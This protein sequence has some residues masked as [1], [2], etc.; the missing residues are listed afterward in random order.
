MP[1]PGDD[2]NGM[3]PDGCIPGAALE[4]YALGRLEDER[5]GLFESHLAECPSCALR[6]AQIR[7]EVEAVR[8]VLLGVTMPR[9]GECV[10]EETLALYLDDALEQDRRQSV[11]AHLSTCSRCLRALVAMYRELQVVRDP[12]APLG[13]PEDEA[14][15]LLSVRKSAGR[16]AGEHVEGGHKQ[17]DVEVS[18]CDD[19]RRVMDSEK[20]KRRFMT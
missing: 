6:C 17:G 2:E 1:L 14:A 11:D 18:Q 4:E 8:S 16:S 20:R 10:G 7:E 19:E 3:K 12:N 5:A 15:V 9:E 13:V